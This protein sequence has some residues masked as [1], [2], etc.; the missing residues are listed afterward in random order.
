[1]SPVP[2]LSPLPTVVRSCRLFQPT[3]TCFEACAVGP[4]FYPGGGYPFPF[5]FALAVVN[6]QLQILNAVPVTLS[7]QPPAL[8]RSLLP[9]SQR[10][11]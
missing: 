8:V 3:L 11:L 9:L 1:M 4:V 5:V 7:P 2:V 6:R 10:L